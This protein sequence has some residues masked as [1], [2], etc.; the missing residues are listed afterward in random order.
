MS[1]KQSINHRA[2]PPDP[3]L[4][5]TVVERFIRYLRGSF[6]TPLASRY[7]QEGLVVDRDTANIAVKRWL[8]EIA[9][10]RVHATTGEV[11]AERLDRE[12]EDLQPVPAIY[13]GR[14]VRLPEVEAALRRDGFQAKPMSAADFTA[15][16]NAENKRW[17]P[18]IERAGLAG[19]GG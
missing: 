7:A 4:N 18:L 1:R 13:P 12:R 15:F 5:S 17:L 19:K 11:P 2:T 3:I 8:R 16:V 10:A 9:N 14:I 6:W